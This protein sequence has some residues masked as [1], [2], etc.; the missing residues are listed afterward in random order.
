MSTYTTARD[1]IVAIVKATAVPTLERGSGPSFRHAPRATLD[2]LPDTRGF[3]VRAT[4]HAAV[5]PLTSG[6]AST[7][8]LRAQ[9]ELSVAYRATS[10]GTAL[11]AIIAAD[12]AALVKT[13]MDQSLW[14]SATSGIVTVSLGGG[15]ILPARIDDLDGARV[16]VL[17][18]PMEYRA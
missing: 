9:M 3:W 10:D 12:H 18:F 13:L 5:G 8:R 15:E 11:D 2:D 16:L 6:L 7:Q 4:A 1:Q 17:T 14:S